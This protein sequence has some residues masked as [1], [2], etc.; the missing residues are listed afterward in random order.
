MKQIAGVSRKY[1][2]LL[3]EHRKWVSEMYYPHIPTTP[4]RLESL[5]GELRESKISAEDSLRELQSRGRGQGESYERERD[6]LTQDL[7]TERC[8][9]V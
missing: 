9:C 7:H 5:L 2:S 8:I 4:H 6:K 1:Q 3:S